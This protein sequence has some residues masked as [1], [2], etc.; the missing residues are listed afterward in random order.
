MAFIGCAAPPPPTEAETGPLVIEQMDIERFAGRYEVEA[1]TLTFEAL[2]VG[3]DHA[4]VQVRFGEDE[5]YDADVD[6]LHERLVFDGHGHTV[7]EVEHELIIGALAELHEELG[8]DELIGLPHVQHVGSLL[9]ALGEALPVYVLEHHEDSLAAATVPE[10][11]IEGEAEGGALKTDGNDG[12]SCVRINSYYEIEY[13]YAR[14]WFSSRRVRKI[15][16]VVGS[17]HPG[18][19]D[20]FDC[21]GRCGPGCD[22]APGNGGAWTLDCLEHD[23]CVG[24]MYGMNPSFGQNTL[25][26][27]HCKGEFFDA[28]SDYFASYSTCPSTNHT[29]TSVS[30]YRGA[31]SW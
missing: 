9:R 17:Y 25:F 23:Y 27:Y 7:D 1:G 24:D 22:S 4:T 28:F 31:I 16:V 3:R 21:M 10:I 18:F 5:A 6:H 12:I 13:R 14:S 30:K 26:N 20:V 15:G 8:D 29:G 19:N 2:H 11:E